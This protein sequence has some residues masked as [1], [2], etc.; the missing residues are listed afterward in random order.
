MGEGACTQES[1]SKIKVN[2]GENAN[3]R[4]C[5]IE[6]YRMRSNKFD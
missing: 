2:L 4:K 3:L 6:L 5:V 1:S